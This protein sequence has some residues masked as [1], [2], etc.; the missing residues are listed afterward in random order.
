ML[1]QNHPDHAY[2]EPLGH[3]ARNGEDHT[4]AYV[5]AMGCR[6]LALE[7]NTKTPSSSLGRSMT[8]SECGLWKFNRL[9][10]SWA[11][12]HRRP[13][14]VREGGCCKARPLESNDQRSALKLTSGQR[15]TIWVVMSVPSRL[16]TAARMSSSLVSARVAGEFQTKILRFHAPPL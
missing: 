8:E 4:S 9:A 5:I 3:V 11:R 12:H 7:L 13:A 15:T 10:S 2:G 1:T 14:K 16:A 6:P